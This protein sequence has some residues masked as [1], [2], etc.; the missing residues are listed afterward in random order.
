MR[1]SSNIRIEY[2]QVFSIAPPKA[3]VRCPTK[4]Y[5]R[6]ICHQSNARKKPPHGIR[7]SVR[8]R[9]VNNH[10]LVLHTAE[11]RRKCGEAGLKELPGIIIDD[12]DGEFYRATPEYVSKPPVA[13]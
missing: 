8:R 3:Q 6:S 2:E 5:V 9:V 11:F 4:A 7:T 13:S 10:Y 12:D 1:G